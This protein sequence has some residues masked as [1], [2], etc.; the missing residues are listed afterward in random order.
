MTLAQYGTDNFC[1]NQTSAIF[2]AKYYIYNLSKFSTTYQSTFTV[3]LEPIPNTN[4]QWL[5][6]QKA[7][8]ML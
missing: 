1:F 5:K 4:K 2:K 7:G 8:A 6:K 3:Y